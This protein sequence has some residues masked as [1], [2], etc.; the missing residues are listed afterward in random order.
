MGP[1]DLDKAIRYFQQAIALDPQ[2]AQAHLGLAY[3]YGAIAFYG[4]IPPRDA[5]EKVSAAEARALEI[6]SNLPNAQG[7]NATTLFYYNWDWEQAEE[8][9]QRALSLNSN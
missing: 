5:W 2:Y 8:G 4:V 7:A 3:S 6:D 9:F 1:A